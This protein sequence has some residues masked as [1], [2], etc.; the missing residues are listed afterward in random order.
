VL[1]QWSLDHAV[2][3]TTDLD[4][5]RAVLQRSSEVLEANVPEYYVWVGTLLREILPLDD[6][7]PGR[8]MSGS[9]MTRFGQVHLSR[10]TVVKTIDMLVHEASH[11]YFHL[12][13]LFGPLCKRDAPEVYSVLKQCKR[14]LEKVLFGYHAAVNI[15]LAL[16][17]LRARRCGLDGAELDHEIR[18]TVDLVA[19]LDSSLKG[20]WE[21]HFNEAGISLYMALRARLA[22]RGV[23]V[24]TQ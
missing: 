24:V 21:Q 9:F 4:A 23:V 5:S 11:Q 17:T 18:E 20:N 10:S 12:A 15:V 3:R 2:E 1:R 16:E 8:S 22:D 13:R 6:I 14:P 19:G 7:G